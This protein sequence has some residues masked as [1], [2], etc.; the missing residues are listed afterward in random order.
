MKSIGKVYRENLVNRV[1][2]GVDKNDNIFIFS[3]SNVSSF[4]IGELRKKLKNAGASVYVSK[5]SIARVALKELKQ[6][7]LADR[8]S[9][10]TAFVWSTADSSEVS[11]ILVTFTKGFEHIVL[12]GG[13]L[14]G[15]V[16][17]QSDVKKLSDLP[18]R[19]VLL[20]QLLGT[21]QAP[22]TRLAYVLNAKSID[23]LSILKQLSEKKGGN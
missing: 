22:L 2:E 11:K 7:E 4:Q 10:Q 19:Q 23:L 14:D 21:I 1:K 6:D 20:G 5:N 12:Q 16:I 17:A 18:S 15:K 3:Y 9:G 13:L 8:V